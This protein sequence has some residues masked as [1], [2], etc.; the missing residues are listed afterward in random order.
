MSGTTAKHIL[1]RDIVVI[2]AS[3]GGIEALT[4]LVAH[5]PADLPASLFV[6]VRISPS[7]PSN[8]ASQHC[9]SSRSVACRCR[10]R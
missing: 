5:L 7:V 3:A 8:L 1:A 6:V 10:P 4:S 9:S 2:G